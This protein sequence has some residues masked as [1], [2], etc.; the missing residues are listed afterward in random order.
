M[1]RSIVVLLVLV[2]A[3]V[4]QANLTPFEHV[5]DFNPDVYIG[6]GQ[7]HTY[8]H[9]VA[10]G[11]P[12]LSVPPDVITSATLKLKLNAGFDFALEYVKVELEDDGVWGWEE[13]DWINTHDITVTPAW[14]NDD[15][16]LKV[17]VT[18]DN[19]GLL[20]ADAHLKKST[21]CGTAKIIPAPGAILLG[22]LGASL[23]GWM[24][25][26]RTL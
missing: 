23:V 16:K 25:R 11:T 13:V 2:F 15:G 3:G 6:E 4:A 5:I 1:K 8:W 22:S 12:P 7:T 21:L 20:Y 17:E 26:R 9:D 10:L 24:R 19:W 18:V 14:V